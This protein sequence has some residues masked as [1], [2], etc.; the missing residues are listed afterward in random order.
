[1]QAIG[2]V[3]EDDDRGRHTTTGRQL[4]TLPDG[5]LVIDTPGPALDRAVAMT[6]PTLGAPSPTSKPSR[7][8]AA[9][10]TAATNGEP[11][12]AVRTALADGRLEQADSR[13]TA[14]SSA[15]WRAQLSRPIAA[16]RAA[17]RSKWRAIHR[18]VNEHMQRKYG[19]D[20]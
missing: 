3:R 2:D 10:V 20:R 16:A 6:A 13:A 1:M 5:W 7:R 4:L 17:N 12:C 14:S 8:I 11:G 15:R 9:S 19:A 18:A